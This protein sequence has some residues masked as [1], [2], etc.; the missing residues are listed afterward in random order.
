MRAKPNYFISFITFLPANN[1][2]PVQKAVAVHQ[3]QSFP[4]ES[5]L[6]DEVGRVFDRSGIGH[7]YGDYEG[8]ATEMLT[9]ILRCVE[10]FDASRK[11]TSLAPRRAKVCAMARPRPMI[12]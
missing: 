9:L 8:L 3:E 12:P 11:E 7:I 6:F 4:K 2:A 5:Y 10:S 1:I